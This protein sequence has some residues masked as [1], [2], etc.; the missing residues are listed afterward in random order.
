[1]RVVLDTNVVIA[2]TLWQGPPRLLLEAALEQ[3][4]QLATSAAL[5]GELAQVLR[6]PKL[7]GRLAAHGLSARA[8]VARY[9]LIS[10][11][12]APASISRTVSG[13]PDDD[14]VLACALGAQA[15]LIVSGDSLLLDLKTYQGIPIVTPAEALKRLPQ[16]R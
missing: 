6:Y 2:G 4:I 9:V 11:T 7:A 14:Q 8:I 1:M 13:D 3:R 16:L 15:D 12:Y 10:D 5:I